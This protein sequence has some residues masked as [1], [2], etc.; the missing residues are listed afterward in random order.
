MSESGS[1]FV[2]VGAGLAGSLMACYLGRAGHQ[3]RVLDKRADP[4]ADGFAGGR[5]IN[6]AL[7]TRGISALREV[8]VADEVL[9]DAVPMQGRLMHAADGE[10]RFQRYGTE[11]DQVINSISR[12]GLNIRLIEK[13]ATYPGVE[14]SFQAR[15]TDVDLAAPSVAVEHAD[16]RTE[17]IEGDAVIGADGAYSAVRSRMQ[18]G[19]RFDYRQDFLTHGYKELTIPPAEDGG[20]RLENDV[21]HIWPRGG[22]MMIALPNADASYTCTLFWPFEG[23]N[24]FAAVRSE[25]EIE[26]FFT[27]QFPDAVAHMPSL[28]EDYIANQT[29]SL[30]TVRCA[31]WN[32]G[33]KV[34]L[35]GDAAHAV[36]P[37]YG[38]GM[39]ASF[40][41]CEILDRVIRRH[42]GDLEAA[43][44]DF[45]ASRRPDTDA[46]AD[47]AIANFVEM[48]D[49]VA[50]PA[51]L[52]RK[53]LG[54]AAHRLFPRWFVP[55][56]S[57][58]TFSTIPYAQAVERARRQNRG[59][60]LILALLAVALV[61][62][63]LAF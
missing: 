51:F 26:A 40:E 21:L 32:V 23:E 62:S 54:R 59:I 3:V 25:P 18:R 4:R 22:F 27:R 14:L 60:A 45:A 15:C 46:L 6:L 63:L 47:L 13:A 57:L 30:V 12:E 43:F 34:V 8:R 44:D 50:S 37:F 31:P 48:R 52:M 9:A 33:G 2:V 17:V 41:D 16:G 1:R 58:V 28:V 24:S 19:D 42:P 20:Y 7:S 11:A 38:Q 10:L 5:S 36:V 56:Y 53:A 29:S 39:N 35:I 49:R 61:A 55:I